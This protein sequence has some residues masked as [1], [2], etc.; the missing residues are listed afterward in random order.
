MHVCRRNRDLMFELLRSPRAKIIFF[1]DGKCLFEP[2]PRRSM[3]N[4]SHEGLT[5]EKHMPTSQPVILQPYGNYQ[6]MVDR[7]VCFSA[8]M[9]KTVT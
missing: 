8:F 9:Y 2:T 3:G 4:G 6:D 1:H 7:M 5:A